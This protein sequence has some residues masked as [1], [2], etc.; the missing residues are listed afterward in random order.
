MNVKKSLFRFLPLLLIILALLSAFYFKLFHYLN[1]ETLQQYHQI[2]YQW[3][4]KNYALAVI[5]FILIYIFAIAIS[6]PGAIFLTLTGGFLFGLLWGTIYV[7]ISATIGATLLFL[8]VNTAIGKWLE[9]RATPWIKKMELGFKRDAFYYLLTLRLI[10]LFPFWLVNIVPALLNIPLR[11][12]ISATLIGIIPGTFIYV[13]VGNGLNHIFEVGGKLNLG[14][15]FTPPILLPL[16][17]LA[18]LSLLPVVYKYF[19][20]NHHAKNP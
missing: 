19:K 16:M 17:G 2:L 20:R 5:S 7:M 6:I 9:N 18:I 1:F 15:I 8:A 13:S 3:T 14:I 4:N 12:F 11:I 10:P